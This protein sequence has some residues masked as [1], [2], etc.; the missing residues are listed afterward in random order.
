MSAIQSNPQTWL[1]MPIPIVIKGIIIVGVLGFLLYVTF[2]A[3][4]REVKQRRK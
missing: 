1:T 4:V 3:I 2:K